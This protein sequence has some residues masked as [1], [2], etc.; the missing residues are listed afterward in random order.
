MRTTHVLVSKPG[1]SIFFLKSVYSGH[2]K[3][4]DVTY[5]AKKFES[6]MKAQEYANKKN[7]DDVFRPVTLTSSDYIHETK[8]N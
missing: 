4:T 7:I 3:C 1:N 8:S 2:I 5:D 6:V